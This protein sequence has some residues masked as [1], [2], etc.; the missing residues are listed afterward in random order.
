MITVETGENS[1]SFRELLKQIGN[2]I[3]NF[4][5]TS[6]YEIFHDVNHFLISIKHRKTR[7]VNYCKIKGKLLFYTYN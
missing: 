3:D 1:V 6:D 4:T 5:L 2:I 7:V